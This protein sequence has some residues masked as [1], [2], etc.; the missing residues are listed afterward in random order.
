MIFNF[1][2]L[3]CRSCRRVEVFLVSIYYCCVGDKILDSLIDGF[4]DLIIF[5]ESRV[6][7]FGFYL[8]LVVRGSWVILGWGVWGKRKNFL[9]CEF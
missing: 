9:V 5:C 7:E 8:W 1:I 2:G 4:V 6:L 3:N